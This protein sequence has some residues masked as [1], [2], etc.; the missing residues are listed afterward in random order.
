MRLDRIT[1]V[2]TTDESCTTGRPG[3]GTR[4]QVLPYRQQV[5]RPFGAKQRRRRHDPPRLMPGR[6]VDAHVLAL[7]AVAFAVLAPRPAA[8]SALA[9]FQFLLCP[10]NA[11][12]SGQLLFGIL[13][14]TDELVATQGR[15]VLPGGERR[16]VGDKRLAQVCGQL[17]HRPTGHTLAHRAT[18]AG[19]RRARFTI[20]Q[21]RCSQHRLGQV[22]LWCCRRSGRR[23]GGGTDSPARR[24]SEP[25]IGRTDPDPWAVRTEAR[26]L[27]ISSGGRVSANVI[28]QSTGP[29]TRNARK[30]FGRNS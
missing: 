7:R 5:G 28:F 30:P 4:G 29:Q 9:R 20:V 27:H 24:T 23:R 11:A 2:E 18:V 12:L 26:G 1:D 22:V 14:P 15:G 13:D 21:R 6:V 10:A 25:R 17:V 3:P 19:R 16:G 8:G